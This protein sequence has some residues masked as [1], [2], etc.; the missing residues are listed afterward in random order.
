MSR[1]SL[2]RLQAHAASLI[3]ASQRRQPVRTERVSA[4]WWHATLRNIPQSPVFKLQ[5]QDALLLRA[6]AALH[7]LHEADIDHVP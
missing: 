1:S 5:R 4:S 2:S 7:L 6:H 3:G